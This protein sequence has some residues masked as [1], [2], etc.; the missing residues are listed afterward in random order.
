MENQS[1]ESAEE[2]GISLEEK[3]SA[4]Y[5]RSKCLKELQKELSRL[6]QLLK[7]FETSPEEVRES[8]DS[9]E[10]AFHE[11]VN[12]HENYMKYEEDAEKR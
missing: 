2:T 3:V 7:N 4:R 10:I 1:E 6:Q 11:F 9:Y 5:E 12:S 8:Q